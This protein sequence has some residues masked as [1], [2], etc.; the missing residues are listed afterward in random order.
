LFNRFSLTGVLKRFLT[1]LDAGHIVSWPKTIVKSMRPRTALRH[2]A[3][4]G[5]LTIDDN[6]IE[7]LRTV[8][9]VG[10]CVFEWDGNERVCFTTGSHTAKR[11]FHG[12]RA[13]NSGLY[14]LR[15]GLP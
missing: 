14:M 6:V 13:A 1:Q 3:E 5:R 2:Y 7:H 12:L 15:A 9:H 11:S 10:P 8:Q 4:H